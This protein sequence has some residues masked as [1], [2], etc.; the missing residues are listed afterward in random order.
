MDVIEQSITK[1][2]FEQFCVRVRNTILSF[3]KESI[4]VTIESMEKR[5]KLIVKTKGNR[6]KY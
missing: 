6:T 1:E 4:D 3:P 5:M 2:S